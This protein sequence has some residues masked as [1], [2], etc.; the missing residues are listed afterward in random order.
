MLAALRRCRREFDFLALAPPTGSLADK[1]S[2]LDIPVIDS[3]LRTENGSKTERDEVERHLVDVAKQNRI[4]LLHANSLSMGRLTGRIANDVDCSCVAHLRDIIKLSKAATADLNRNDLLVAVSAATRDFHIRQG[5]EKE[6]LQVLFNGVDLTEFQPRDATG[7]L[8]RELGL[9]ESAFLTLTIGQIGLR[10]GLEVLAAAAIRLK[11]EL[12]SAHFVVVGERHS[13]KQESI[14]YERD[15]V[16]TFARHG[17]RDRLHLLGRRDDVS[18]LMNEV[19]ALVH[20]AHQ[21]PLGRVILEAAASGLPIV[22]TDVG[23]TREIIADEQSGKRIPPSD[24]TALAAAI[25]TIATDDKL[26]RV[27]GRKARNRAEAAFDINVATEKLA[28]I[29][30]SS[31]GKSQP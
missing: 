5:L 19:D 25:Q 1:L 6:R 26:R 21:E 16:D 28:A 24:P 30:S 12:P 10:K 18:Q 2:E 15:F 20:A 29:W 8:K 31:I 14:D 11:N 23:G 7:S 13:N 3:R 22:A 27:L 17:M 4:D 9:P